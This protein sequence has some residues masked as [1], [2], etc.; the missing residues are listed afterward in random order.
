LKGLPTIALSVVFEL[1]KAELK[2]KLNLP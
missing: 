2:K 1:G